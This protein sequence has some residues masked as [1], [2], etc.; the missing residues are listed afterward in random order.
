MV[1]KKEVEVADVVVERVM[2]SKMFEPL[3]Q[4]APVNLLLS[5]RRVEDA[6]PAAPQPVQEVTVRAPMVAA[7]ENK[8]VLEAVVAKKFVE[9]ADVEVDLVIASN[10]CAPVNK[11]AVYVLGIVVE[12]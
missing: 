7:A 4:F 8:F 3:N 11:L 2:L 6:E 1:E 10:I 12:A 5:A 9:V